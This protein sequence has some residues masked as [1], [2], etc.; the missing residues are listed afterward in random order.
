MPERKI[1]KNK[2]K[3]DWSLIAIKSKETSSQQEP[4]R[5]THVA[6][7]E[8]IMHQPVTVSLNI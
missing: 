6:M 8:A 4:V 3:I 7:Y 1:G 2:S 5:N